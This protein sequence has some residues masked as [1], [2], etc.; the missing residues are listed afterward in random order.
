MI[1]TDENVVDLIYELNEIDICNDALA[2][3]G[4]EKLIREVDE[5]SVA[6]YGRRSFRLSPVP[7]GSSDANIKTLIE[8]HLDRN[9]EP[10]PEVQLTIV[11]NSDE[12]FEAALDLQ[13]S[14][15]VTVQSTIMGMEEDFIIEDISM[16][17][18]WETI[19]ANF[20]LVQA[21]ADE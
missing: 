8:N 13:I 15:K 16:D 5:S 17:I 18:T 14:D 1:F 20:I 11:C 19:N 2:I 3:S 9:I 7:L 4:E 12:L 21:R 10:Y 6:K